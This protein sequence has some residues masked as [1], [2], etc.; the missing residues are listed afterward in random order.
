MN[1]KQILRTSGIIAALAGAV[2][3]VITCL[4]A[5]S[6]LNA[7]GAVAV[8]IASIGLLRGSEIA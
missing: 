3:G 1:L 8:A 4:D 2:L 6:E 7:M 5:N